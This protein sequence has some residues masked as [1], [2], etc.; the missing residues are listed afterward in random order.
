[1]VA[2]DDGA[3]AQ[4]TEAPVATEGDNPLRRVC[5]ITHDEVRASE[6]QIEQLPR[7]DRKGREG[8]AFRVEKGSVLGW[9]LLRIANLEQALAS[10]EGLLFAAGQE[11]Q[12]LRQ[13]LA[14]KSGGLVIPGRE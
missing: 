3:P 12:R 13:E 4:A 8:V 5:F 2:Q 11:V 7:R 6:G 10:Q 1:M 14:R 9:F